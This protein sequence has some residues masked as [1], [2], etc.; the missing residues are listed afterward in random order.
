M[1]NGCCGQQR[2]SDISAKS[3]S[4]SVFSSAPGVYSL[5]HVSLSR[6]VTHLRVTKHGGRET[7]RDLQLPIVGKLRNLGVSDHRWIVSQ[8]RAG[9]FRN[10]S[11]NFACLLLV[12]RT[13]QENVLLVIKILT[14]KWI[15]MRGWYHFIDVTPWLYLTVQRVICAMLIKLLMKQLC[16]IWF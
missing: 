10:V 8:K 12:S 7:R 9:R 11:R 16:V 5:L 4:L 3:G 14:C 15:G 6:R 13:S 2:F 1:K